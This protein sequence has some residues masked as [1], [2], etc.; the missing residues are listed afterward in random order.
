MAR[1]LTPEAKAEAVT[2]IASVIAKAAVAQKIEPDEKH[3]A[4]HTAHWIDLLE[5]TPDSSLE[6]MI[7]FVTLIYS[8]PPGAVL[9]TLQTPKESRIV[10]V[11]D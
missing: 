4:E 7:P 3:I 6:T 9:P 5:T 10:E 11:V 1:Q 2:A 8:M